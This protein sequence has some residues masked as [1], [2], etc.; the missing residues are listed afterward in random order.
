MVDEPYLVH[1][2]LEHLVRPAR[3]PLNTTLVCRP[4]VLLLEQRRVA[5]P[6]A[7]TERRIEHH[8]TRVRVLAQQGVLQQHLKVILGKEQRGWDVA[9]ELTKHDLARASQSTLPAGSCLDLVGTLTQEQAAQLCK[10]RRL[11][12]RRGARAAAG[13]GLRAP[14]RG[15]DSIRIVVVW[16]QLISQ[17]VQGQ[18]S[19]A[20]LKQ[21]EVLLPEDGEA[22]CETL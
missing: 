20:R 1:V 17:A 19:L 22:H 11:H 12:R 8:G 10:R 6:L 4:W 14:T 13:H 9:R 15:V 18:L 2:L 3:H 7:M 21:L 5:Q 16:C